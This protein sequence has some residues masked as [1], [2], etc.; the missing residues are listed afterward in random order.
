M[1]CGHC[2]PCPMGID[3]ASVTKF[4][5]LAVAQGGAG[6]GAGS[7]MPPC[8]IRRGNVWPAAPA[9]PGVPSGVPV[10]E[11]MKKAGALFGA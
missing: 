7:T 11:N 2:A 5:H 8:L 10:I 1:Y 3:V 9:S 6:D 4:W